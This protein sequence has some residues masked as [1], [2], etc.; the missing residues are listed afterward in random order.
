[1][2]Q[3]QKITTASK[4]P[5]RLAEASGDPRPGYDTGGKS[6]PHQAGLERTQSRLTLQ[7]Q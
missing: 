6:F 2:G 5:P 3:D 1:M 7:G 4:A